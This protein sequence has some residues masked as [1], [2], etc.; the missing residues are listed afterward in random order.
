M[1]EKTKKQQKQQ[2]KTKSKKVTKS[3]QRQKSTSSTTSKVISNQS[4]DKIIHDPTRLLI[5]AQLYVVEGVDM[6]FLKHN[7][8]L[9]WGNLSSHVSKLEQAGFID[10][11]KEIV[12]KKPRTTLKITLLG[13][14]R[15]LDYREKMMKLL[16]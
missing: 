15:F 5:L 9:T 13:Q 7:L 12:L 10:V 4:F 11:S 8:D 3:N 14:E 2:K 6:V 1:D 16:L